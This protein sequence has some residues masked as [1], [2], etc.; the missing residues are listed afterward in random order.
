MS[1][2]Y[3]ARLLAAV[4][5]ATMAGSLAAVGTSGA[6]A[7]VT[8]GH[9]DSGGR[10]IKA[11]LPRG[12]VPRASA[13]VTQVG[14]TNWSGYAQAPTSAGPYKAVMS[15]W[16]VAAVTEPKS[17]NQYSSDWV[18][19]DGFNNSTLV[20]CGTESDNI[21]GKAVYDA[22]TE[23]LPASEVVISGLAIHAGD[24]IQA[25]VEETSAN[26]WKMQV[27]DLTT[28][29]SGGRTVSYT[30][31][32]NSVEVIHERP[33]INGSLASLAKTGR[34]TQDP[35]FYGTTINKAPAVPLMNA[36]TGAT[37][38]QIFMLNN[39]GT[40]VI[41]SPSVPDSDNDGFTVADSATSPPP[42]SS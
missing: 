9:P 1:K 40:T 37:V 25:L 19:I 12:A 36:A 32:G 7:Q 6:S 3:R 11:N 23:I 38:Y 31:P 18:G 24:R 41:A 2:H 14:S 13:S 17:G 39:A 20:Q 42:P 35:G 34:V 16:K 10:F 8:R 21:G 30:T 26:T 5:V 33:E 28:G 15:T 4:A 22:W 27:K 29:K